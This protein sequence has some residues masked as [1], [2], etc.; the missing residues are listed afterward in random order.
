[1]VAAAKRKTNAFSLVAG[2]LIP[3][4]L[5]ISIGF[6]FMVDQRPVLSVENTYGVATP[7]KVKELDRLRIEWTT[8]RHRVCQGV[9][10][11]EIIDSTGTVHRFTPVLSPRGERVGPD[12]WVSYVGVPVRA[13]WGPAIYRV[14]VTYDCG[15]SHKII[16][17]KAQIP[18]VHFE[19]VPN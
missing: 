7:S 10:S 16:R 2:H 19:I 8:I 14:T 18:D 11:R 1:M 3:A 12:R 4:A 13:A 15:W 9:S 17:L 5:F 6:A